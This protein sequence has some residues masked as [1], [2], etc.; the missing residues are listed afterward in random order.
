MNSNLTAKTNR[1]VQT[2]IAVACYGIRI[3]I[4]SNHSLILDR[5][6]DYL[7]PQWKFSPSP[8][9]DISYSIIFDEPEP[10]SAASGHYLLY[11][12]STKLAQTVDPNE[13][14]ETLE[15][16]LH[17]L[18]ASKARRKLFVHAGVIGWRGRAII[19]P[20]Y[21]LSGK[22]TLVESLVRA[23]ATYYSDEYAVLDGQGRVHPYPK[24][25]SIR[26]QSG[27]RPKKCPVES[28]G[29]LRGRRPIP[30]GLIVMTK[31][32]PKARWQPRVLS[33]GQALLEVLDNTVLARIRSKFALAVL[34]HIVLSAQTIKSKRAEAQDVVKVLLS[35]L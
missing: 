10:A 27:K 15:S 34:Q 17:F 28:I 3:G 11:E 35:Y 14:L 24:S 16:N 4:Q 9:V 23:G 22:T 18:V 30:V 2:E 32:Q 5:L 29:G 7:P 8:I 12:G 6:P 25:L 26:Q 21:S 1:R 13:V 33:P 19:I 20:G 31:Y